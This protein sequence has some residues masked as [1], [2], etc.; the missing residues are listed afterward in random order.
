MSNDEYYKSLGN[1]QKLLYDRDQEE[2]VSRE[3]LERK[4]FFV[5]SKDKLNRLNLE[6]SKIKKVMKTK[7]GGF[8]LIFKKK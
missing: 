2:E 3:R 8:R 7:K 1:Y 4:E 5:G 6:L